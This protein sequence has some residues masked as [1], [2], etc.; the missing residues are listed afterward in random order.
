MNE[1]Q[2]DFAAKLVLIERE[3]KFVLE[4]LPPGVSRD[5]V[6]HIATV[7]RLLRARLDVA[8]SLILPAQPP[9]KT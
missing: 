5:R 7:A 8:S 6:Q 2:E 9:K 4:D 1:E 3:A